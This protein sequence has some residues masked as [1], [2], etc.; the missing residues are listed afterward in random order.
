MKNEWTRWKEKLEV[1]EKMCVCVCVCSF[2]FISGLSDLKE[3]QRCDE[4]QW[5]GQL[6]SNVEVKACV[7]ACRSACN[8]I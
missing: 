6:S 8:N 7:T 4:W 3:T 5:E 2:S 1:R